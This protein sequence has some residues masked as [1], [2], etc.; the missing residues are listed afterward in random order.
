M[1][2]VLSVYL[3]DSALVV[4][5]VALGSV[6]SLSLSSFDKRESHWPHLAQDE[7]LQGRHSQCLKT[8][9]ECPQRPRWSCTRRWIYVHQAWWLEGRRGA[10][11]VRSHP[12][13]FSR[14]RVRVGVHSCR[15]D[16]IHERLQ[17]WPDAQPTP[18]IDLDSSILT[19]S[20]VNSPP[21]KLRRSF[22]GVAR[23]WSEQSELM[24]LH[25]RYIP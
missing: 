2:P 12:S 20:L 17:Y 23:E 21:L 19:Q 15:M 16:S 1:I 4:A 13:D 5:V 22:V 8:S 24:T 9:L 18:V 7:D 25:G 6:V 10:R 3:Q 14:Y 11:G